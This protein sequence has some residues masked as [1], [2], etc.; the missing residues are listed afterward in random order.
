M[1]SCAGP[2]ARPHLAADLARRDAFAMRDA[3]EA[4]S[5]GLTEEEASARLARDGPNQLP[6]PRRRPG[7]LRFADQ[8][9]HFFALMLW[10]AGGLAIIAGL[11]QLGVAIF[12]VIVLNAVF[13]FVQESRA[14]HAAERLRSL[15]PRR[16]TVRRDGRR[17]EVDASRVVVGDVLVLESGDRIPADAV[18]A[19][20]SD[21]LV[22]TSLL[23][24]ESAPS[25]S[26]A[27]A[28]CSP[29]RSWSRARPTPSSPRPEDRPGWPPSPV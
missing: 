4:R 24:G 15:L 25:T 14:D 7:I 3:A 20:A 8:L 17:V 29:A 23:T 16:V 2:M 6:P 19:Y 22:D 5:L 10:V 26:S 12:V 1:T 9:V 11:P 13:S 28:T 18:A 21:L 27:A